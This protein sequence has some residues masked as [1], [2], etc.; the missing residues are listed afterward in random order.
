MN[1]TY[2]HRENIR[3]CLCSVTA[4]LQCWLVA[5]S[6][7]CGIVT[8]AFASTTLTLNGGFDLVFERGSINAKT[9]EGEIYDFTFTIA[10]NLKFAGD[11]FALQWVP[12]DDPDVYLI[13]S[14]E[15]S[16]FKFIRPAGV[17][18]TIDQLSARNLDV[19]E[20]NFKKNNK[21]LNL[22]IKP[23]P[24]SLYNGLTSYGFEGLKLS[25]A[26]DSLSIG[27]F[28]VESDT[29]LA[30]EYG[31]PFSPNTKITLQ[32]GHIR[33]QDDDLTVKPPALHGLVTQFPDGIAFAFTNHTSAN[34]EGSIIQLTGDSEFIINDLLTIR[35]NISGAVATDIMA[36]LESLKSMEGLKDPVQLIKAVKPATKQMEFGQFDMVIIDNGVLD[37]AARL[38]AQSNGIDI[39]EA[40]EQM[41]STIGV[42]TAAL[43]IPNAAAL[44][45]AA[46]DF[47]SHGGALKL[48]ISPN[49]I[50]NIAE[51][52]DIFLAGQI[53]FDVLARHIN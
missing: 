9:F 40:R 22:F 53:P 15:I 38:I 46:K 34:V 31:L 17:T 19:R 44:R 2:P 48:N 6:L 24:A 37:K 4:L 42:F 25:N 10:D 30:L 16:N 39:T 18:F 12:S 45:V 50:P 32:D 47:I 33:I 21:Q 41:I 27:A 26:A 20:I 36:H 8:S 35:C 52:T 1:V 7:S 28:S 13:E 14:L 3:S 5:G 29:P 23:A 51:M 11:Y 49:D 43:P